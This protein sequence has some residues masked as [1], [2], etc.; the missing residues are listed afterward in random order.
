MRSVKMVVVNGVRYR[1]EDVPE[2]VLHK[3]RTPAGNPKVREPEQE[4]EQEPE[5][6]PEQEPKSRPKRTARTKKK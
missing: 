5:P 1:P 3:M 6:E 2:G 4:P